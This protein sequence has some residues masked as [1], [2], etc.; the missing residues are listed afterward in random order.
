MKLVVHVIEARDL[1]A[2]DNNGL[3]DTYAKLQLRRQRAKTK[4]IKKSL[5]PVWDEE[6]SFRVGDLKAELCVSVLDE[7][8]YFS[9][10][11][12][13]QI[14][15]P[16]SRLL[17]SE[18]LS[19]GTQWYRL[20]P[21]SKKSKIK[22]SGEICI[23]ISLS[24]NSCDDSA[25]ISQPTF[26]DLT[27]NSDKSSELKRDKDLQLPNI[28]VETLSDDPDMLKDEKISGPSFLDRIFQV[29]SGRNAE[30]NDPL[31][32][33]QEPSADLDPGPSSS[34]D[35]N[36]NSNLSSDLNSNISFNELLKNF[37]SKHQGGE[38]PENL[39]GGVLVDQIY[40]IAPS[41]LNSILFSPNT[42]F[43]NSLAEIQGTMGFQSENWKIE[44]DGEVMKRFVTYTKAATKLVKAVKATE[45][46][47]YIRVENENFAV[48]CSVSTPD[49]PF[50]NCFRVEV[51]YLITPGPELA[52]E[53]LKTSRLVISWRLNFL[54]ST[55][56]KSMIENGAKQGL[57]DSF[58]QFS[59]LLGQNAK[60]VEMKDLG[61][62]RE[63][64][65]ASV[66]PERE[67][68]WRMA[69]RFFAN[70]TVLSSIFATGY[71]LVHMAMANASV[72]QGLEFPGLD[73]PDSFGELVVSGVLVLQG[74]RVLGMVSRFLNARQQKGSD[75]GVKAQG[76]GWLLTVALLE[77]SNL[78][79]VDSTGSDPYVVFTC[80]GQSKTS[81][82][83]FQALEPQWNEIFE[84]DA[85]DDP[86]SVM[87]VDVYGFDG[88]FEEA[89]LLGHAEF[90]FV[91]SN[92][93]DL[94]DVWVPLQ[95]KLAQACQSR[96]HLRIFLDNTKGNN[97]V[98]EYHDK[99]EREVGKKINIRSPQTNSAFQKI[100][101]LPPEEFL[102]NDFTC[103][104]K[105]K[106]RTQGRLFLSP[107]IIGFYTN[108]FGHKT[109][110]FFL[111]ED[112]EDIQVLSPSLSS[113]GSPSI[114]VILRKGRGLD[115]KHGAKSVDEEGRLRFL[116]QSF[117]SF[118]VANRTIMALWKSR[119]LSPEQKV[120][121]VEEDDESDTKSLR[122]ED[123]GSFIGMDDVTM[124]DVFSS[125]LP[126]NISSVMELYEGGALEQRVMEKVGCI[127]YS[128]TAW[129]PVK[130]DVYQRQVNFK[131]GKNLSK[132]TGDITSTQQ[133]S[134]LPDRNGFV[135]EEVMSI[136]GALLGDYFNL[137][138]RYQIEDQT[139]KAKACLVS[140]SVGIAW[141]KTTKHQ[142]KIT[143]NA[144]SSCG[145]RMKKI[146]CTLEKEFTLP[147]KS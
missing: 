113:M 79:T 80:N 145:S 98:K 66:K 17:D 74:Q 59:E 5:N 65:L 48:L 53:E 69:L 124:S 71:V 55:M 67:S 120:Q 49:V 40:A 9:D 29:F 31:E 90:N 30:T 146:F 126:L 106:M 87:D 125:S 102:I 2:M 42:N 114:L 21:K 18:N 143:K 76:E 135:I 12:L 121:L 108:L 129:E 119:S 7:D 27:S 44:N 34:E 25:L 117:V 60:V 118:N 111:W 24:Q 141:L 136:Q 50:G 131:F 107:R 92:L 89:A 137:H 140:A 64:M 97:I 115:A 134:T 23:N 8:K 96:L 47:I 130:E 20:Q 51:L 116:F 13:G 11:T 61:A 100:F 75:H 19:L 94:S 104:L 58:D 68:D 142:K 105:R 82:I 112:I 132:Y 56:M 36:L 14:K 78:A 26:D 109:K 32:A 4:V 85:M 88:P 72:I 16:L 28:G 38:A 91:K 15:V 77:G 6:F 83:K 10:D 139:P 37:E 63:Q 147:P 35:S 73:L 1:P 39:P 144:V 62:N 70:F 41:D 103:H 101:G 86:P 138:L 3:S 127:D 43:W 110:F 45:E 22:T 46:Q 84:F 81:S 54:Q 122:S 128:V 57:K 133:K 95:G 99:V 33:V 52:E 93:S 123:S